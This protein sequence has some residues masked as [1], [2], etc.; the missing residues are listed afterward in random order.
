MD[1][2]MAERAIPWIFKLS[3]AEKGAAPTGKIGTHRARGCL[4]EIE[5]AAQRH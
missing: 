1:D 2:A 3:G 4:R 5:L